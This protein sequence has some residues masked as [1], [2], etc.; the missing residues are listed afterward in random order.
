M[1]NRGLAI[2]FFDDRIR[3]SDRT[4]EELGHPKY[5]HLLL[6]REEKHMF[7]RA[8]EKRDND[9]FKV[10]RHKENGGWCYRIYSKGFV[11]FLAYLIGVPYPSDSVWY[12]LEMQDDGETAFI[13]LN[14]FHLIPY[15]TN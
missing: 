7:I 9:T 2:Y 12:D 13:D 3:I 1:I 10:I 15:N 14:D 6:N 8:S 4:M 5:I 11:K